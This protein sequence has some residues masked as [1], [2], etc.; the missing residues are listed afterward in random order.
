LLCT[1]CH[2]CFCLLL[3]ALHGKTP[4]GQAAAARGG[5]RLREFLGAR[6][7]APPVWQNWGFEPL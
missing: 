5:E 2:H 4:P 7:A 1:E 3:K 6:A